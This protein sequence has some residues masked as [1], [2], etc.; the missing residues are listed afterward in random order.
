V[1]NI[2]FA[3]E[4]SF[5]AGGGGEPEEFGGGSA[6]FDMLQRGGSF[7]SFCINGGGHKNNQ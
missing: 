4:H 3:R 6:N 2:T 5:L 1:H 7:Y